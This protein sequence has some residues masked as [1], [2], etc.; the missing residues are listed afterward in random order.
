MKEKC[1]KLYLVQNMEAD[2]YSLNDKIRANV[3]ATYRNH[4]IEPITISKWCQNWLKADF[5]RNAKYA[6]NGIDLENFNYRQRNFNK[7][8]IR[9]LIEGDSMSEYKCVDESFNIANQ[10]D[11]TK[12][13]IVYLSY[14]SQP[15][16]W[17]KVD[18]THLKIPHKKV[19][20]IYYSCDILIKSSRLESFSYPPLEMMASG[21][22]V[23]V[24]PNE[25]NLEYLKDGENCLFYDRGSTESALL[26]VDRILKD[27]D[28]RKKL[29]IAGLE[30]ARSYRWNSKRI[31]ELY[32]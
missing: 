26:A 10:L 20:S 11:K 19:A 23:V 3:Y 1:K 9:I 5:N 29:Y 4:R 27:F 13:E 7:G 16:E 28:L 14:N 8:K 18:E 6:P 22:F 32:K 24:A 15:K 30:T 31:I 2:F 21:G 12:F 25:G 17:Y